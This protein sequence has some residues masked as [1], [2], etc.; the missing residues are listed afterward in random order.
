MLCAINVDRCSDIPKDYDGY[1]GVP[2]TFFDKYNPNQSVV[3]HI[4]PLM[5]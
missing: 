3:S 1:M 4:S 5:L 2:I